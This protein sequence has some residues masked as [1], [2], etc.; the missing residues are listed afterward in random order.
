MEIDEPDTA[1]VQAFMG[2]T[3]LLIEDIKSGEDIEAIVKK[4]T[5]ELKEASKRLEDALNEKTREL[6][7]VK[8]FNEEIFE[9]IKDPLIVVDFFI[10]SRYITTRVILQSSLWFKPP[11]RFRTHQRLRE[12]Y[13][14]L[15]GKRGSPAGERSPCV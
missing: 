5:R 10:H 1:I 9:S 3:E 7:E 8:A 14:M 2:R 12:V 6:R 15:W 11:V 4:G 13:V